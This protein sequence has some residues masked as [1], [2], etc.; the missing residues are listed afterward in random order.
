VSFVI[1]VAS[2]SILNR[3]SGA[4]GPRVSS[5]VALIVGSTS[6]RLVP[7]RVVMVNR[8]AAGGASG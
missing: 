8:A 5:P 6:A 3:K 7:E 4:T 2:S 1:R